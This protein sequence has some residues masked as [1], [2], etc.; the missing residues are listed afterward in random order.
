MKEQTNT[1]TLVVTSLANLDQLESLKSYVTQ[2]MPLLLELDG[3]VIKRSKINEAYF[4]QKTFEFLL[5]MDFPS[6]QK[7]VELFNSKE[8]KA[9]IPDR[10]KGFAEINILFAEDLK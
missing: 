10:D 5:V 9:L 1:T 7:L 4:G 2:V 3:K 8:Y 6:K